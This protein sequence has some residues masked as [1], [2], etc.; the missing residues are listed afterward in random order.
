M[1][2]YKTLSKE[3]GVAIIELINNQE[4]MYVPAQPAKN[5]DYSNFTI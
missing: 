2:T 5:K 3:K 1:F 4:E